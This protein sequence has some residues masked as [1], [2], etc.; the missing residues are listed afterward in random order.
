MPPAYADL[1]EVT[2]D[3]DDDDDDRPASTRPRTT[4]RTTL[5]GAAQVRLTGGADA[6]ASDTLVAMSE[7]SGSQPC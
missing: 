5:H 3:A 1:A 7:T 2:P 6:G 4:T